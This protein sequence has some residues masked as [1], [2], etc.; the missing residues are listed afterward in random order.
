MQPLDAR[1]VR[2]SGPRVWAGGRLGRVLAAL[3]VHEVELLGLGV[4]RLE[5]VVRDRPPGRDPVVMTHLAEVPLAHPEEDGAV[6][7]RLAPDVVVLPGVER[8]PVLT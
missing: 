1:L 8:R 4:I 2:D 7:L 6:E 3:A 5:I